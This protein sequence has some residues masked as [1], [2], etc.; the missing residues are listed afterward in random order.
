MELSIST[1]RRE[2]KQSWMDSWIDE[3][4]KRESKELGPAFGFYFI[5]F[6]LTFSL[7]ERLLLLTHAVKPTF[8]AGFGH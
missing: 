7:W 3:D 5:Q 8:T 2:G 6:L 4:G 1:I